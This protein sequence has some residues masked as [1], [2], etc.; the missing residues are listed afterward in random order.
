MFFPDVGLLIGGH[1]PQ[2][3]LDDK[4][5]HE[6]G[7]WASLRQGFRPVTGGR[8]GVL[9]ICGL[10]RPSSSLPVLPAR[11]RW[12]RGVFAGAAPLVGGR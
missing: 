11:F 5:D 6:P 7:T 12:R 4:V 9:R 2:A 8:I 3:Y 1:P 10:P